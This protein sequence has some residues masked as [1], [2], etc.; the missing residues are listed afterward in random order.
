MEGYKEVVTKSTVPVGT[1]DKVKHAIIEELKKRHHGHDFTVVSNPEFLKEGA[2]S[3]TSC[4]PDRVIV[5]SDDP[6]AI[7]M[8][9]ALY[10]PF[11]RNRERIMVWACAP[12]S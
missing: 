6:R 4:G 2:A 10:A 1:A 9:R 7:T 11:Q 5:G 8:L 3:R 12:P